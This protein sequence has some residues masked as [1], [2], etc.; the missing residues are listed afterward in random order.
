ML[1]TMPDLVCPA[2]TE[3]YTPTRE[4]LRGFLGWARQLRDVMTS[5]VD[6]PDPNFG[7]DYRWCHLYPY[8]TVAEPGRAVGLEVRVRNHL[9]RPALVRSTQAA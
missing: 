4:D 6:Q 2:H 7:V 3:E 1:D 9:F 5:L 8:R